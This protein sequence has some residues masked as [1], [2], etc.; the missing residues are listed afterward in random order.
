[1]V[2][3]SHRH[4]RWQIGDGRGAGALAL[5]AVVLS[6]FATPAGTFGAPTA[7]G[8]DPVLLGAELFSQF[9]VLDP[10]ANALGWTVSNGMRTQL[11]GWW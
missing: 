1:M 3:R 9:L 5:P 6:G 8:R 4:R 11:G 7:F 10:A 2:G